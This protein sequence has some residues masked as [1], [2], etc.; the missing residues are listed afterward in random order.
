MTV[1]SM[2][3]EC[4]SPDM[5]IGAITEAIGRVWRLVTA[6][7]VCLR[8]TW[9]HVR[10]SSAVDLPQIIRFGPCRPNSGIV[11]PDVVAM[12]AWKR[13]TTILKAGGGMWTTGIMRQL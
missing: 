10:L 4:P 8:G 1:I 12:K 7:A 3:L 11:F 5:S 9:R 6:R 13:L 2:A